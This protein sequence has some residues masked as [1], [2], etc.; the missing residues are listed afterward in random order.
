MPGDLIWV[1]ADELIVAIRSRRLTESQTSTAQTLEVPIL[2]KNN[3]VLIVKSTSSKK[4]LLVTV[5]TMRE[6]LKIGGP[7]LHLSSWGLNMQSM[8]MSTIVVV[9]T[10]CTP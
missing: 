3:L 10:V 9:S 2:S 1:S 7:F 6:V 4:A 5:L 8:I